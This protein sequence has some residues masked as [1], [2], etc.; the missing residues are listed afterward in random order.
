[1]SKNTPLPKEVTQMLDQV[2]RFL[3]KRGFCFCFIVGKTNDPLTVIDEN[4][5]GLAAGDNTPVAQKF[6]Q[7]FERRFKS[8]LGQ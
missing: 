4:I 6:Q 5:Y 8:E 2:G 1:M 3:T 7:A